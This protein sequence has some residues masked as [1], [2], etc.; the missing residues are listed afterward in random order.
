MVACYHA[1][2]DLIGKTDRKSKQRQPS[3][4]AEMSPRTNHVG[5]KEAPVKHN[6]Q[7]ADDKGDRHEPYQKPQRAEQLIQ[8]VQQSFGIEEMPAAGLARP[9]FLLNQRSRRSVFVVHNMGGVD[10]L[11]QGGRLAATVLEQLPARQHFDELLDILVP[12]VKVEPVIAFFTK[13]LCAI[14]LAQAR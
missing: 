1:S 14:G 11:F 4:D 13:I 9:A 7:T 6:G 10:L 2:R 3:E 12:V 8:S 5:E